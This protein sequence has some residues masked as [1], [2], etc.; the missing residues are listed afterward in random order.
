MVLFFLIEDFI[1][2]S[3]QLGMLDERPV[4]ISDKKKDTTSYSKSKYT[5]FNNDVNNKKNEI[6]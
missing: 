4:H 6:K 5:V 1:K 3:H 2:H